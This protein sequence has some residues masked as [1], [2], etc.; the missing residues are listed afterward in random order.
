MRRLLAGLLLLPLAAAAS[1]VDRVVVYKAERTM[2]L[3]AGR[4]TVRTYPIQLGRNP[5]GHK[6]HQGDQRTPEGRYEIVDRNS[7]SNYF[8]SLRLSYPSARD[9]ARAR[10][11]GKPPGGDIMIHGTPADPARRSALLFSGPDW[12]DGCIAIHN[13][14]MREVWNLVGVGTRVEIFP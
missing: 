8:R 4:L 9:R 6:Q 1:P 3:M 11:L 12:T 13:A 14:H 5:L 10:S 7:Q 2:A